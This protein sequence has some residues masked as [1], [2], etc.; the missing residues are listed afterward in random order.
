MTKVKLVDCPRDAIQ[1]LHDFI[2]TERKATYMNAVLQSNIFD[3]LDF[4]SFVSPKAIPQMADTA[5]LIKLLDLKDV[6]TQ[7]LAIVANQRGAAE[8]S[9]FEEISVL[10]YPFSIS[11]EFQKRNTNKNLEES[12]EAVKQ[13][14]D[15]AQKNNKTLLVYISMAF[16]N[17]YGEHWDSEKVTYWI[18][19]LQKIGVPEFSLADTVGTADATQIKSVFEATS[20]AFPEMNIGAHF[21]AAPFEWQPKIKAAYE[22]GCRSFDGAMQGFGGCP[23]AKDELVGNVPTEGL[24]EYFDLA[25]NE[26]IANFT[27]QFN[28]LI[29]G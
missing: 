27:T 9:A 14:L 10:G 29:N 17:P 19:Q 24:L 1:G 5:Q 2:P 7:L 3:R 20:A 6:D 4:G 25:N 11:E 28:K 26:M 8:A 13:I 21:H 15:I 12:F 18:E 22:A 23:M 16:G